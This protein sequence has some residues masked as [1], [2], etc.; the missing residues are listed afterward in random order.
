MSRQ[1]L[2]CCLLS[3]KNIIHRHSSLFFKNTFQ[4]NGLSL[5]RKKSTDSQGY[6]KK[7]ERS[8]NLY[9]NKKLV[10][11][12]NKNLSSA[13]EF[14]TSTRR[15]IPPI[16]WVVL[17]PLAK[18][19]AA[20]TGRTVRIWFKRLDPQRKKDILAKLKQK[21]Y[22]PAGIVFVTALAGTYYYISH[23]EETPITGRKR[24]ITF[25]HEQIAKI[26]E[27]EAEMLIQL[28]KDKYYALNDPQTQRVLQ[29]ARRLLK[30][31]PELRQMQFD[32]WKIFVIKD[33]LVNACVL[34]S[35]HMF[36]FDG[37]LQLANTQDQ[38]AVILG[39]EMAHAVLGHGIEELSYSGAVDILIIFCLA[40]IWFFIPLD[41]FAVL[42][43]WLYNRVIQLMM[44]MPH[45]RKIESEADRVGL[46]FAAKACYDVRDGTV[47]WKKMSFNEKLTQEGSTPEWMQT[48]PDSL[49]RAEHIDFLLPKAETWRNQ[50]KCPKLPANDPRASIPILSQFINDQMLATKTGQDLRK[51]PLQPHVVVLKKS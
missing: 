8:F 41:S 25:T 40:V 7:C 15:Q 4:S 45:S 35:G 11:I 27:A 19:G 31:N 14:H 22:I 36:V 5:I 38:L 51:V 21:W 23:L 9:S 30:A 46:M 26:S 3:T 49:K 43:H 48:H 33:P 39:H 44:H 10:C 24:F 34:P 20:V 2:Q 12:R 18:F 42:T 16:F 47:L 32:E 28:Y 6:L 17:K 13:R 37:I 50:M 29:V 1:L